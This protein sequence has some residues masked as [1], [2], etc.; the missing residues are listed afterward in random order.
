MSI[1]RWQI[2]C[3]TEGGWTQG[4]LDQ[5]VGPPS[6][7]F[8]NPTHI[9][10]PNSPQQLDATQLLNVKVIQEDI[11][12]GGHYTTEGFSMTIPPLTT[13]TLPVSWP[14]K[15]TCTLVHVMSNID[16]LH[17]ILN[18][19]V[20]PHTLIGGITTNIDINS[21]IAYVNVTVIANIKIGFECYIGS[22]HLGRVIGIDS[23]NSKITFENVTSI[24]HTA[25]EPVYTEMKIIRNLPLGMN[26]GYD[27]GSSSLGGKYLKENVITNII[28]TNNSN[29]EKTFRF[30]VEYLF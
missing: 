23:T 4:L 9:I 3:N 11:P 17:D 13:Q 12:T 5:T 6:V 18:A 28:Y 14:M 7:C 16:N 26:N 27:L 10:N 30:S 24:S 22:E 19:V 29:V 2:Y 8:N 1:I 20:N 15:T 21:N 25:G